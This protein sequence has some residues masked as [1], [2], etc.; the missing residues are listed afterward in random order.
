MVRQAGV[1][2]VQ[3]LRLKCD[4]VLVVGKE[5]QSQSALRSEVQWVGTKGHVMIGQQHSLPPSLVAA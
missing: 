2:H 5:V 4:G 1:R 3:V